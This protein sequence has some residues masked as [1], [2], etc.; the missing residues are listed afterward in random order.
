AGA[1]STGTRGTGAALGGLATQIE[2]LELVLADG[3]VATCSA[4]ERPDL[5]AAARVSLGTLGILTEVTLRCVPA[6]AL[7]A[8]EGPEPI[9]DVIAHFGDLAAAHDHFEFYWIPN[10]RNALVKQN[11][12]LPAGQQAAPLSAA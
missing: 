12:R 5:F 11:N 1:V 2:A 7:A 10:G 3:T 9:E 4:A 6:F 8:E